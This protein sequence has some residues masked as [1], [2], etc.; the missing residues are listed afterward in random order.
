MKCKQ[1][2]LQDVEYILELSK[3]YSFKKKKLLGLFYNILYTSEIQR[4]N[5][6]N[7][8]LQNPI[9]GWPVVLPS[10][11]RLSLF[12]TIETGQNPMELPVNQW[13]GFEIVPKFV[14]FDD[15]CVLF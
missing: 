5:F 15:N 3:N 4:K 1:R 8:Q 13:L 14:P 11:G 9:A 12:R 6:D 2:K 7:G 10:S